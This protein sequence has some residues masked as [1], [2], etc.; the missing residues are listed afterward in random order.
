[1]VGASALFWVWASFFTG[2][3]RDGVSIFRYRLWSIRDRMM[4]DVLSGALPQ[5]RAVRDVLGLV[6][7]TIRHAGYFSVFRWWFLPHP[8]ASYIAESERALEAVRAGMNDEQ[9]K[10]LDAYR[11]EA[12]KCMATHL[13]LGSVLGWLLIPPAA[14]YAVLSKKGREAA[15]AHARETLA[16]KDAGLPFGRATNAAVQ[17]GTRRLVTE[18]KVFTLRNADRENLAACG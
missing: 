7:G 1:V 17:T 12:N 16:D 11:D 15:A 2:V 10:L 13:V 14:V 9:R 4:D 5:N 18:R 3:S 8:P 6:E